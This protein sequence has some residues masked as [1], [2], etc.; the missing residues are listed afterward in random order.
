MLHNY[1]IHKLH[2]PSKNNSEMKQA[3][4]GYKHMTEEQE[5]HEQFGRMWGSLL[6]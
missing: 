6:K 2:R 1:E 5:I 3:R 4:L